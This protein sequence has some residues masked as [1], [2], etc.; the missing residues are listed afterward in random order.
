V[1]AASRPNAHLRRNSTGTVAR[2]RCAD[3]RRPQVEILGG[4]WG[5]NG[6]LD[7]T[8]GKIKKNHV[9][10]LTRGSRKSAKWQKFVKKKEETWT[11]TWEN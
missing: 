3:L 8:Q 10:K 1:A 5:R 4:N 2:G 7:K 9:R 11:Q 6:N